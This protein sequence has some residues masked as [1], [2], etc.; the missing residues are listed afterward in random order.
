[1]FSKS[2]ISTLNVN[3]SMRD[4]LAE[5]GVDVPQNGLVFCPFHLHNFDT[6]SAKVFEEGNCLWCFTEQRKYRPFD[7]MFKLLKM[8]PTEARH[9]LPKDVRIEV[10]EED[11]DT[12]R[13]PVV[14]AETRAEFK[15][16]GNLLQ[17][18]QTLDVYWKHRDEL[19]CVVVKGDSNAR[20]SRYK[21]KKVHRDSDTH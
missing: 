21:D 11:A 12:F 1:M 16:T 2:L 3:I 17:Y 20:R 13:L 15:D 4:V 7:V 18:L 19:R 14:D 10:T 8:S 9:R 6:K 5:A